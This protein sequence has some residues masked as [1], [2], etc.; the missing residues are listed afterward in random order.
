[1]LVQE[2]VGLQCLGFGC[3]VSLSSRMCLF[4]VNALMPRSLSTGFAES[5]C[6]SYG[7]TA[8]KKGMCVGDGVVVVARTLNN[9]M[10][11]SLAGV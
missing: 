2:R 7:E 11:T 3:H 4:D 10:Q 8:V 1:M 9:N 5:R 6:G